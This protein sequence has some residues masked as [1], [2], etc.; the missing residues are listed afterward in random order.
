MTE[1]LNA[2][3]E[4]ILEH[5]KETKGSNRFGTEDD[6]AVTSLYIRKPY[7]KGVQKVRITIEEA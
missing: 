4:V 7:F 1:D 2:K 5:D 3:R 6:P